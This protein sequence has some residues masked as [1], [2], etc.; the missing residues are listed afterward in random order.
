MISGEVLAKMAYNAGLFVN[1]KSLYLPNWV[2]FVVSVDSLRI[3]TCDDYIAFT[4]V[5]DLE[6]N[7]DSYR[8]IISLED[9]K[10]LEKFARANKKYLITISVTDTE[11]KFSTSSQEEDSVVYNLEPMVDENWDIVDMVLFEYGD[12]LS[13]EGFIIRPERLANLSKL[14]L[15]EPE[16]PLI[17]KWFSVGSVHFLRAKVGSRIRIGIKEV[18]ISKVNPE[19]LWEK[20]E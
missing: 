11:V 10:S 6:S 3:Y 16:A 2:L 18:N 13:R 17:F 9:L 1:P 15:S 14:K 5:T 19:Y 4:E 12:P 8:F 7:K 20:D